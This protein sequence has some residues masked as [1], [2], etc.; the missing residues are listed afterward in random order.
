PFLARSRLLRWSLL[1]VPWKTLRPATSGPPYEREPRSTFHRSTSGSSLLNL[2]GTPLALRLTMLRSGVPPNMRWSPPAPAADAAL[3]A[4]FSSPP[5]LGAGAV[6]AIAAAAPHIARSS[7][8]NS[9]GRIEVEWVMGGV[10][11][12]YM[13]LAVFA[14]GTKPH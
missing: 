4:A 13:P 2:S 14:I 12:W 5:G 3:G 9:T 6:S 8:P 11:V 1:V 10:P 7:P